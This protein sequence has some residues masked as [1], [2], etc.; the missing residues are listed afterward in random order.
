[1]FNL[2]VHWPSRPSPLQDAE[3]GGAA[4]G[5]GPVILESH[6]NLRS[7]R[8]GEPREPGQMM[9]TCFGADSRSS[10]ELQSD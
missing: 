4:A 3:R 5:L 7:D 9:S 2:I 8:E 6:V 10:N 1:M